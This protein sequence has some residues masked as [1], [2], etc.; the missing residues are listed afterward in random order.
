MTKIKH[1]PCP[2][3]GSTKL[4][5][6]SSVQYGH[7]DCTFEGWI[8]C[9]CGARNGFVGDWGHSTDR[10]EHEA[11]CIWDGKERPYFPKKPKTKEMSDKLVEYYENMTLL[12]FFNLFK[13][14]DKGQE[15][16]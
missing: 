8:E 16:I 3:C 12:E 9:E 15:N 4:T 13:Q 7:G 2:F 14:N 10:A 6:A 11:W 5:Y 1:K